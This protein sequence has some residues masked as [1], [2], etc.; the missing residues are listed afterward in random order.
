MTS[1]EQ[2]AFAALEAQGR[3]VQPALKAAT[4]KPGRFGFRGSLMVSADPEIELKNVFAVAEE[5]QPTLSMVIGDL[6]SFHHVKPLVEVLGASLAAD[7]RYIFFCR[8]MVA[9]WR[10]QID[11]GGVTVVVIPL[12][13][14][15]VY[16]EL[17]DAYA[18]DKTRMKKLDTAA[19]LDEVADAVLK[20]PIPDGN[21]ATFDEVVAKLP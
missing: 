18:L 17:I 10:Y 4:H 16:N 5:S 12:D 19:K 20:N 15:S 2:T 7:G 8:D 6:A 14:N 1:I 13:E 9:G 11:L 21:K 3:L